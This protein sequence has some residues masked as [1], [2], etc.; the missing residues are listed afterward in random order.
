MLGYLN[1]VKFNNRLINKFKD[2]L[3]IL[4]RAISNFNS[5]FAQ[6]SQHVKTRMKDKYC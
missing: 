3:I 4:L 2:Y 6:N 5:L 1:D